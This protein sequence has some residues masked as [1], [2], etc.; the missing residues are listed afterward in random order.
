MSSFISVSM[1][2]PHSETLVMKPTSRVTLR[3]NQNLC[4][5]T[6]RVILILIT[7]ISVSCIC[8]WLNTSTSW[9]V[10]QNDQFKASLRYVR[11]CLNHSFPTQTYIFIFI[12]QSLKA[13]N[14]KRLLRLY[15]STKLSTCSSSTIKAKAGEHKAEASLEHTVFSLNSINQRTGYTV[16]WWSPGSM[17]DHQ[18]CQRKSSNIITVFFNHYFFKTRFPL[19]SSGCTGTQLRR[20]SNSEIH[21]PLCTE[22]W[23]WK[24]SHHAWLKNSSSSQSPGGWNRILPCAMAQNRQSSLKL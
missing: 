3:L 19:C 10:K 11:P 13:I 8:R 4:L 20:P 21:L 9:E 7:A 23:D 16:Q 6:A 2:P 5:R 24:Y 17:F 18:H 1:L 12:N 14:I 15:C 22:C